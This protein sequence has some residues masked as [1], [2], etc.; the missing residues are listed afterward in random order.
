MVTSTTE[1][2]RAD[3]QQLFAALYGE[4]RA[5]AARE[6]RLRP[7]LPVGANTLVHEAYLRL[8]ERRDLE[9]PDG[10]RFLAYCA[11]AMRGIILDAARERRALKRGAGFAITRLA[12]GVDVAQPATPDLDRLVDSIERLRRVEPR[13]AEV[14]DLKYFCGFSFTEIAASRGAC[15]RTVQRDW[16]RA[17]LLLFADIGE[18]RKD[19]V[20]PGA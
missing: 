1:H 13:L 7:D 16:E 15:E 20:A 19:D 5:I 18:A 11:Q 9:F 3:P 12:T 6:L 4:L 2:G 8:A 10:S 17:R 14:V